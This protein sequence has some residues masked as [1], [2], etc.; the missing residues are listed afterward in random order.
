MPT[1]PRFLDLT[2]GPSSREDQ[3][4]EDDAA[5]DGVGGIGRRID[6][7]RTSDEHPLKDR[8]PSEDPKPTRESESKR[9]SETTLSTPRTPR[10]QL[11]PRSFAESDSAILRLGTKLV[12]QLSDVANASLDLAEQVR[13]QDV[14]ASGAHGA[15]TGAVVLGVVLFGYFMFVPYALTLKESIAAIARDLSHLSSCA[16]PLNTGVNA[17]AWA[18]PS[19]RSASTP[20]QNQRWE[21]SL[22]AS[23][24]ALSLDDF[25]SLSTVFDR[26]ANGETRRWLMINRAIRCV[27]TLA[28]GY[29]AYF[30]AACSMF[31]RAWALGRRSLGLFLVFALGHYALL[32]LYHWN[33]WMP[34]PL[35]DRTLA[36]LLFNILYIWGLLYIFIAVVMMRP[37]GVSWRD[38]KRCLVPALQFALPVVVG[39]FAGI[40][41]MSIYYSL[42]NS[43]TR[44]IVR[45]FLVSTIKELWLHTQSRATDKF[46]VTTASLRAFALLPGIMWITAVGHC[47]Q[48]GAQSLMNAFLMGLLMSAMEIIDSC[49]LLT[50]KT[51]THAWI[52]RG[53]NAYR[54][55]R[56]SLSAARISAEPQPPQPD[57]SSNSNSSSA[58][59]RPSLHPPSTVGTAVDAQNCIPATRVEPNGALE[60]EAGDSDTGS[61]ACSAD[62]AEA[63]RPGMSESESATPAAVGSPKRVRKRD[64]LAASKR[65]LGSMRKWSSFKALQASISTSLSTSFYRIAA[66]A[67]DAEIAEMDTVEM[68]TLMA[69]LVVICEVASCTTVAGL[70]VLLPLAPNGIGTAPMSMPEVARLWAVSM[71]LEVI[72]V[73]ILGLISRGL[74][75]ARPGYVG[76][77][78][79]ALK[80]CSIQHVLLVMLIAGSEA[81]EVCILLVSSMCIS[82]ECSGDGILQVRSISPCAT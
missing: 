9:R 48:L 66:Q 50:G 57:I 36:D 33:F 14:W 39:V 63:N 64:L 44:T 29:I 3:D 19:S 59:A 61:D 17:S 11:T 13:L 43:Q 1:G 65:S 15:R 8:Q 75:R 72:G 78:T 42:E 70:Y 49:Y 5:G 45:V 6:V 38:L 74:S 58:P 82:F 55:I 26:L 23:I 37:A 73:F 31:G 24:F 18:A 2:L 16:A 12:P 7:S 30:A 68:L 77:V 69:I 60:L 4:D 25:A 32:M 52:C 22:N 62:V 27:N 54:R 20:L 21:P 67:D 56:T 80:S 79:Q 46:E 76:D 40:K 34:V 53:A 28:F 51:T 35:V 41:C 47:M 71:V 10:K 81:A